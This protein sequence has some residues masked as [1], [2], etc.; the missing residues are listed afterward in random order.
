MKWSD[1]A[2][3]GV[4]PLGKYYRK[5]YKR[6]IPLKLFEKKKGMQAKRAAK[7][8]KKPAEIKIVDTDE[9]I[10]PPEV[11]RG[12]QAAAAGDATTNP[13]QSGGFSESKGQEGDSDDD[14]HDKDSDDDDHPRDTGV[15]AIP[16]T[17]QRELS[18]VRILILSLSRFHLPIYLFINLLIF[19]K[20]ISLQT[21]FSAAIQSTAKKPIFKLA[22]SSATEGEAGAGEAAPQRTWM[23]YFFGGGQRVDDEEEQLLGPEGKSEVSQPL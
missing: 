14:D 6:N 15:G 17:K 20:S 19:A 11:V 7:E 16:A 4:I 1:C 18:D 3:E 5:A 23:Q 22:V 10:P 2:G 9:D 13:L 21:G 8:G 12:S